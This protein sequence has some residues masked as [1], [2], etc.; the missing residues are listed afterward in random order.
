MVGILV[1][2]LH[3][4]LILKNST[5]G[6]SPLRGAGFWRLY[7]C[8][9][10]FQFPQTLYL[11]VLMHV[12]IISGVLQGPELDLKKNQL[13]TVVPYLGREYTI[14]FELFINSYQYHNWSNILHFTR[15]GDYGNYG[16]RNPAIWISEH[17]IHVF[18][19]IDG[20]PNYNK[21]PQILYLPLKTWFTVK[22]SQVLKDKKV[23]C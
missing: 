4:G 23:K 1:K 11:Y 3:E 5:E 7:Y 6:T 8:L 13:I 19:S 12:C 20:N 16:D 18:S 9:I 2:I 22:I 21:D 10:L 17:R 14:T 15:S